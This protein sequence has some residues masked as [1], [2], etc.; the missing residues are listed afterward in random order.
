MYCLLLLL[1]LFSISVKKQANLHALLCASTFVYAH[2]FL[3]QPSRAEIEDI[4]A[5][6]APSLQDLTAADKRKI[7]ERMLSTDEVG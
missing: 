2:H 4:R 1:L 6:T 5:A 7:M 3:Y